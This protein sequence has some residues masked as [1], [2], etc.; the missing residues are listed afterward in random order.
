M[1]LLA[2]VPLRCLAFE[3][4]GNNEKHAIRLMAALG[5]KARHPPA[6]AGPLSQFG[7]SKHGRPIRLFH[8]DYQLRRRIVWRVPKDR[9]QVFRRDRRS[10]S[11]GTTLPVLDSVLRALAFDLP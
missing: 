4:I 6:E 1:C 7:S 8:I 9:G 2:I 11:R 5:R 10:P 3:L